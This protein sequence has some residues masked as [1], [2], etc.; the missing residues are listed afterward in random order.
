ML[1]WMSSSLKRKRVARRTRQALGSNQQPIK[2]LK[3]GVETEA[4]N[5]DRKSERA[6]LRPLQQN[7]FFRVGLPFLTLM[8]ASLYGVTYL[9]EGRYELDRT[10]RRLERHAGTAVSSTTSA[11]SRTESV[12]NAEAPPSAYVNIPV[13]GRARSST[14]GTR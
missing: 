9:L 4:L 8:V 10:R 7:P 2:L 12:E 11:P 5:A 14:S 1:H 13:P 6:M 3:T